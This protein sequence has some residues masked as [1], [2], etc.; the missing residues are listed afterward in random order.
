VY[1]Y[2]LGSKLMKT[3]SWITVE[4]AREALSNGKGQ[5]IKIAVID[6]GIEVSH[7]DLNGLQLSDD[8]HVIGSDLQ[9][10]I[11]PGDGTDLFGHGTA[12]AAIIRSLAPDA[13]IGSFRVLNENNASRTD[14]ICEGV[15]LA[16][17]HGYKVLNCSFGCGVAEH[18]HRYKAWIDQAY[19]KGVHVVAACNNYDY[20]RPE[21]PGYFPSVITVNYG[22]LKDKEDFYFKPGNLVEF[23]ARGT[24]FE[25]AWKGGRRRRMH[26]SS[27]AAPHGAAFLARILS[28]Y[29]DLAPLQAKSLLHQLAKPWDDQ[30]FSQLLAPS[31]PR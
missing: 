10:V 18:I 2:R 31:V 12:V 9:L 25:A 16:L 15:N 21:W 29:P 1:R 22:E 4:Q 11:R 27:F 17:D 23:V 30:A 26:G 24:G 13:T 19:L 28:V 7:P 3:S 8:I 20:T 6:S 5:G 14:V